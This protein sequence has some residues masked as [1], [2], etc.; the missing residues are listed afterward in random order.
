MH[1]ACAHVTVYFYTGPLGN[2]SKNRK[3]NAFWTKIALRNHF[4]MLC[5]LI[6]PVVYKA[7]NRLVNKDKRPVGFSH[8]P[9]VEVYIQN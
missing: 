9:E 1:K 2:Y 6:V 4:I 7:N 3:S 5:N 8:P